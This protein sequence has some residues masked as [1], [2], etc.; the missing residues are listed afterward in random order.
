MEVIYHLGCFGF[1]ATAPFLTLPFI[2]VL[3]GLFSLL[4]GSVSNKWKKRCFFII[5]IPI[6]LLFCAQMVYMN[7]FKQPLLWVATIQGGQDA[8]TNYW[9]EALV[10]IGIT[11]PFI[12]LQALPA[13]VLAVLFHKKIWRLPKFYG[14]EKW[15]SVCL[16][17]GAILASFGILLGGKLTEQDYYE[18]YN[19]FFDPLTIA[20]NMGVFTLVQ[21]DTTIYLGQ[22]FEDVKTSMTE[23]V[24]ITPIKVPK[25]PLYPETIISTEIPDETQDPGEV[26]PV[27]H[28]PDTSP[29]V[30]NIDFTKLMELSESKDEK[31][32]AN[33]IQE[34]NPTNRNE[35]T[36]IFEGYNLIYITAE[37][38]SPY[39]VRED[40]TPTLYRLTH[41]GFVFPNYYVPLWQTS[42]IDGE[43][44]NLTGL[45]PDGQFSLRRSGKNDMAYTLPRYFE[46]YGVQSLA[47][48][49]NSL[50]YY[51]RNISHNN[52][53]Y[54]FKAATLG[55]LQ[56]SEWGEYIFPMA[57]PK[58]WP[59]SDLDMMVGSLPEYLQMDRFNIY[60]LTVSGHMNYNFGGNAMSRKNREAVESLPMSENAQAYIACHIEL[61]KALE[62]LINELEA[63][64][65]LDQ[66]VICMSA[67]HYPYAMTEEQYEELAGQDL[68]SNK[69][70]MRNMLVL[71][72]APM[73]DETVVVEKVCGSMDVLP[74]LLNL[75]GF[76]YD[77]RFYAGRD[78][79]SQEEGMVIFND[80]SFV[81]DTV[82]YDRKAKTT[83]WTTDV[84]I[85]LNSPFTGWDYPEGIVLA[86]HAQ[87][88]NFAQG[89]L[90]ESARE[91]YMEEKKQEL[92][93]RYNFSAYIL[94]KDY[95]KILRECVIP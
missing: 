43:Y 79:F 62:Y 4:I 15:M 49:N 73:E 35:Y 37:G 86:P 45:I 46:P 55:K 81:T 32:L 95:Y 47:F 56:E 39:A 52:L 29:N 76:Q 63:A 2:L 16:S 59:A 3:T 7:I 61:D 77:S 75:F 71:W 34:V 24:G 89:D 93:D 5:M 80:R 23:E 90:L 51:D 1:K 20:Q 74:T 22:T 41:T 25:E 44:I 69:D 40:L 27:D 88:A 78:I 12:L 65:K 31:W 67:D 91:T 21:R 26:E 33:Y 38:F 54:L 53:G 50:S 10:G 6:I 92:K 17:V 28:I 11:S 82:F 94:Q 30:F 58:Q 9:R 85:S 42:T 14:F 66:T 60:Y 13:I 87:D 19:E 36:G 70:L 18:E 48:H 64:G 57:N 84:G 68:S 72:N 8:L 83:V